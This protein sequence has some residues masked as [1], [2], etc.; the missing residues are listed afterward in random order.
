MMAGEA[1]RLAA[2]VKARGDLPKVFD[3]IRKAAEG[4]ALKVI[5]TMAELNEIQAEILKAE[6]GYKVVPSY[7]ENT[8]PM[9]SDRQNGW[10]VSWEK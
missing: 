7:K 10:V 6:F 8:D 2:K 4:G 3:V 1:R 9:R 5:F